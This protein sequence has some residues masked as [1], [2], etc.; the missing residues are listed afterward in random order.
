[1][2][3]NKQAPLN[4]IVW[5][6][7]VPIFKNGLILKQLGLAI[8]IPFGI[9]A[10]FLIVIEAYN[11]LFLIGATFILA[12]LLIA[13]VFR[14]TYDIRY[15]LNDTDISCFTQKAQEKRVKVFSTITIIFGLF[16]SNPTITGAGILSHK[17]TRVIIPF[18]RIRK[19]KCSDCKRLIM[20][21]GGFGENIALFCTDE[22]YTMVQ[23]F[24]K[25]RS[26]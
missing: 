2:A 20:V 25:S 24:I 8:G 14:G 12:L 22:N 10:V 3:V 4:E 26:K 6:I 7:K 1:M 13:I 16:K 15:V 23:Q 19:I 18:K 21:Y 11:S 17:S 5:E 9:L